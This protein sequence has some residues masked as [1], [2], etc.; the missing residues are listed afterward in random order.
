ME[1]DF[2]NHNADEVVCVQRPVSVEDVDEFGY[3]DANPDVRNAGMGARDHFI[4]HGQREGRLQWINRDRVAEM[5][6]E[7]LRRV[8]FRY[9]PLT[10]RAYGEAANF[11]TP[12]AI[13]EFGIPESPPVSA[14]QYGGPFIDEIRNNLQR[15]CL[16]IGAGLRY[17]C[18]TNVI[19][20][21]IYP[22]VS[23]DVLCVGEDLPF[24]DAQFDYAICADV[25]EHTRRPWEV[26]WEIC[27]VL[28]PGGKL[29]VDYPFLQSV[30]GYPHHYFNAT[31]Q[32]AISL[33]ERHCEILSSN[34]E[35]NNHPI[36]SIWWFLAIWRYGLEGADREC[37]DRLTIGEILASPSNTHL[38]A[39]F[40]RNLSEEAKRT[41]PAGSTLIARKKSDSGIPDRSRQTG[42]F[43][44]EGNGSPMYMRNR[45]AALEAEL[46]ALRNSRSWRLTAPLRAVHGKWYQLWSTR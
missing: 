20:T 13:A 33:F 34:I 19:N 9:Q 1:A 11:L 24:E 29:L 16:D 5:R 3:L 2:K 38:T 23:T 41:I 45:V 31:P 21:E 26:A 15:L 43:V 18:C 37:F 30:H 7:K 12:E 22:S 14:N 35:P 44:H 4:A 46:A 17:S 40:C 32:G 6:E 39:P 36:E 8:R 25:L 28:K 27:R 10:P 42:D